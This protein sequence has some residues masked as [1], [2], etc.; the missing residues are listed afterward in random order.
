M[1]TWRVDDH[2]MSTQSAQLDRPATNPSVRAGG[3]DGRP[4]LNVTAD[5]LVHLLARDDV[6]PR[7]W[8]TAAFAARVGAVR[9]QLAA[10]TTLSEL[11]ELGAEATLHRPEEFATAAARLAGDATSVALAIRALELRSGA[12]R[13]G[14]QEIL[15]RRA[16]HAGAEDSRLD[17]SLWFG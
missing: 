7:L 13:P 9:A 5:A 8:L 12:P 14:W 11:A 15:R 2:P 10:A 17:A 16:A 4:W 3:H 6:P 1:A